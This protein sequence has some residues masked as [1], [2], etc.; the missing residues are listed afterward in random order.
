MAARRVWAA[1]L[2]A[3]ALALAACANASTRRVVAPDG[4]PAFEIQCQVD[5]SGCLRAADEAC[6]KNG[7][8]MLEIGDSGWP[9]GSGAFRAT[10]LIRCRPTAAATKPAAAPRADAP[11]KRPGV[12]RP[13]H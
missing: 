2:L 3:V 10:M 6:P 13:R 1:W 8:E 12:R 11:D 7:F 9:R 4:K 5:D